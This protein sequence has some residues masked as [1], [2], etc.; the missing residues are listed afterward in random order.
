MANFGRDP[1]S[2]VGQPPDSKLCK[3][4]KVTHKE[5]KIYFSSYFLSCSSEDI[6]VYDIAMH[7]LMGSR[8]FVE[9]LPD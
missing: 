6:F 8:R 9:V 3:I 7:Q 2:M 5:V 1:V 4:D